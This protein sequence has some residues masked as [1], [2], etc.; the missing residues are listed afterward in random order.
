MVSLERRCL[1]FPHIEPY[2]PTWKERE[3]VFYHDRLCYELREAKVYVGEG[4]WEAAAEHWRALSTSKFR[5]YRFMAAYNM[6]L[7]YEM[8][9]SIDKAIGQL[10]LAKEVATR[11]DKNGEAVI[12]IDTSLADEYRKA[13][14]SRRKEIAIVKQ[15]LDRMQ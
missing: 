1:S 15:Y 6:A 9:D 13:L 11:S 2:F 5:T 14:I 3:R 12:L 10:D 8:T 7:Y 4:N